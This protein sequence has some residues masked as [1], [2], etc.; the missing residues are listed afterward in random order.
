MVSCDQTSSTLFLFKKFY[1]KNVKRKRLALL[2]IAKQGPNRLRK[3]SRVKLCSSCFNQ[4]DWFLKNDQPII[5]L[6]TS[7]ALFYAE[8]FI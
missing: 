7:V 5:M 6:K 8:N 1:E 4:S 3:I 2:F